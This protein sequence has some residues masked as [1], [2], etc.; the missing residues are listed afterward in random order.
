[1]KSSIAPVSPGTIESPACFTHAPAISHRTKIEAMPATTR[2]R[3]LSFIQ[4]S[5]EL[6]S[7]QTS[8][9]PIVSFQADGLQRYEVRTV[10]SRLTPGID[11]NSL[12]HLASQHGYG[13]A[14]DRW[15]IRKTLQMLRARKQS[16][17]QLTLSL[18]S[19]SLGSEKFLAWLS[20]I[21]KQHGKLS[22][23]LV[24]QIS[25]GDALS[26]R[27]E[28]KSFA[29]CLRQHASRL[30]ITHFDGADDRSNN[31]SYKLLP[32]NIHF[33]ALDVL[34]LGNLLDDVGQRRNLTDLVSR[35]N[36]LGIKSIARRVEHMALLPV[37]WRAGIRFAQG[38]CLQAPSPI[39]D[40]AFMEESEL[41]LP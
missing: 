7:L 6:D 21:L 15:M 5:L 33:V 17:L 4:K 32:G 37:L 12:F 29:E 40:F 1:M 36:A 2:S 31:G 20:G 41:G 9:Q 23:Q 24:F 8:F 3:R 16:S 11:T 10:F 22:S 18:T 38:Y 35:L 28:L 25:Q 30:C 14:L 13:E 27:Q 34:A 39:L 19:N 26:A